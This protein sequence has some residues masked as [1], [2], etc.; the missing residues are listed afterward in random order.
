MKTA[1]LCL[2]AASATFIS[3]QA[4]VTDK[5]TDVHLCCKSCVNIAQKTVSDKAP[6]ATA[7]ASQEDGTIT[8]TGPDNA[9]VQ[10]AADALIKAGYFGTSTNP[11]IKVMAD[12]GAKGQ[13]VKTL[14]VSGVH[15]C[16]PKCVTAVKKIVGEV[17]GVTGTTGVEKGAKTFQVTGDFKD[18]DVFAALQK[19]GLSGLAGA[20]A[21]Q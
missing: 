21:G 20:A 9:T 3:A 5:I 10:K 18:S 8:I 7:V 12:S 6:G 4:D 11:D 19:G 15:L 2:F 17:P 16:C 1:F 14:D 13:S